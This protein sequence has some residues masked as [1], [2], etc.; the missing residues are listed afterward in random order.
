MKNSLKERTEC[1]V[2]MERDIDATLYPCGHKFMCSVCAKKIMRAR[3]DANLQVD[4][5]VCRNP[6]TAFLASYAPREWD[7]QDT[8]TWW[9]CSGCAAKIDYTCQGCAQDQEYTAATAARNYSS[10]L[11]RHIKAANA[12]LSR[13]TRASIKSGGASPTSPPFGPTSPKGRG[14]SLSSP[15]SPRRGGGGGASGVLSTSP[16]SPKARGVSISGPCNMEVRALQDQIRLLR[17]VRACVVCFARDANVVFF[18]CGHS[19]LCSEC[20]AKHSTSLKTC[21][22][23]ECDAHIEEYIVTYQS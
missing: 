16:S 1:Q 3:K 17:A 23:F 12:E 22:C 11:E 13:Q 6:V 18:P 19:V 8:V 21:T 20:G 15:T 10:A 7:E 9:G 4:C 2:C 14:V 5:P